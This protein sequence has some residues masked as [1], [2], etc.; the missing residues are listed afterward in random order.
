M[1][2]LVHRWIAAPV[3]STLLQVPRALVVSVV[4]LVVDAGLYALLVE[5]AGVPAVLANVFSYLAGGMVQYVLCTLWVFPTAPGNHAAGFLAF[6]VLSLVGLG[7]SCMVI[8]GLH[9]LGH[10]N[11]MLAKLASVGLAFTWN[12]GSRKLLLFRSAERTACA[13]EI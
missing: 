13:V 8:Y 1:V 3:D 4:A 2:R 11:E 6:S 10:V 9:D 5:Q 7:L 12:F